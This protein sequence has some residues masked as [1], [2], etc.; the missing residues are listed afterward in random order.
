[1]P[2]PTDAPT[3]APAAAATAAS[4]IFSRCDPVQR[5][6]HQ[7]WHALTQPHVR[8]LAALLSGP[9]LL[10]PAASAWGGQLASPAELAR[11]LGEDVAGAAALT[12]WLLALDAEPQPLAALFDGKPY[13][14]LGLYAEK[15]MAFYFQ[16][17]GMLTL[18]G[19]QVRAGKNET[20]GEFDF[21]LRAAGGLLHMELATKFYLFGDLPELAGG[22]LRADD[23]YDYFVGPNLAD[24]LGLKMRKIFDQQLHLGEHP[25]ARALLMHAAG[26][27]TVSAARAMLK[28]CLF[29]RGDYLRAPS[30]AG[31][32]AGHARGFWCPMAQ[33][34][35][36][37]ADDSHA[38]VLPKMLWLAPLRL[39]SPAEPVTTAQLRARL[40]LHFQ[41]HNTPLQVALLEL[42]G[43]S[44]IETRR[45][46]VVAD[47]WAQ[48]A[49]RFIADLRAGLR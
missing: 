38:M 30:P 44:W 4:V 5:A 9:D 12:A 32:G 24:S 22:D 10:D 29:Y 13:T 35:A 41:Q 15:L 6:F 16:Q 27:A 36:A 25:A 45:G 1:M 19:L 46:F 42:V 28:G 39:P 48:R 17:H 47:D 21:L 26:G 3:D 2:R 31:L 34:D 7:R 49:G 8:A 11:L 33:W 43:D 23:C 14:R 37:V 40:Q 20:V 18:H